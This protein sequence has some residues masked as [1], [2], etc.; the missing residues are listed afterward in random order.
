M[1]INITWYI[2]YILRYNEF[3]T[4]YG[5]HKYSIFVRDFVS[6]ENLDK[7]KLIHFLSV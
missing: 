6:A 2:G 4:S 5:L 1:N 7:S 3:A